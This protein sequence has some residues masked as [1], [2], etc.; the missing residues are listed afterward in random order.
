MESKRPKSAD[1][2]PNLAAFTYNTPAYSLLPEAVPISTQIKSG[3][4]SGCSI[5][6]KKHLK[7]RSA[8]ALLKEACG[9]ETTGKIGM[10]E[11]SGGAFGRISAERVGLE[12]TQ[13]QTVEGNFENDGAR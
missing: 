9:I 5:T 10:F 1:P 13:N 12:V 2:R 6:K 8:A 7:H 4:Y 11:A 3:S